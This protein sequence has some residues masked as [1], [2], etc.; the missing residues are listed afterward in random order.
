MKLHFSG[1]LVYSQRLADALKLGQETLM[2]RRDS[3]LFR[4][5]SQTGTREQVLEQMI[6]LFLKNPKAW[7][8]TAFEETQ[9]QF[10]KQRMRALSSLSYLLRKDVE[11]IRSHLVEKDLSIGAVFKPVD[12][13]T[14]VVATNQIPGGIQDETLALLHRLFRFCDLESNDPLWERRRRILDKYSKCLQYDVDAIERAVCSL[15]Q[16]PN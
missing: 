16:N 3:H 13:K 8:G 14:P 7:V 5:L 6:S 12:G 15:V 10:H 2:K 9:Q 11:K 4:R 1:D